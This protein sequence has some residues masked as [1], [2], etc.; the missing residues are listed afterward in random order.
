MNGSLVWSGCSSRLDTHLHTGR[1][2]RGAISLYFACLPHLSLR[3]SVQHSIG[4][5][6][7]LGFPAHSALALG[8][9]TADLPGVELG[10]ELGQ[11]YVRVKAEEIKAS[12]TERE[13]STYAVNVSHYCPALQVRI[14]FIMCDFKDLHIVRKTLNSLLLLCFRYYSYL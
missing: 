8:V 5:L 3:G 7:A 9:P 10:L 12:E 11:C 6:H 1:E 2:E 14:L 13:Q 4:G